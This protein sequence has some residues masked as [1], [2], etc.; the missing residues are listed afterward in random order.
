MPERS[1]HYTKAFNSLGIS[2]RVLLEL[3]RKASSAELHSLQKEKNKTLSADEEES[4]QKK[5]SLFY[6]ESSRKKGLATT[7]N[8]KILR[9]DE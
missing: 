8:N 7:N 5:Q 2:Q 1:I 4:E 3:F 9:F 6:G